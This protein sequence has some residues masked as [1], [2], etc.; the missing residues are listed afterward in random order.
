MKNFTKQTS[1]SKEEFIF[2]DQDKGQFTILIGDTNLDNFKDESYE[3]NNL[4]KISLRGAAI[5]KSIREKTK[6]RIEKINLEIPKEMSEV[7]EVLLDYGI[8]E[9]PSEDLLRLIK[10]EALSL[11]VKTKLESVG[12]LIKLSRAAGDLGYKKENLNIVWV[13]KDECPE[14][15]SDEERK[16]VNLQMKVILT[17]GINIR[18][19]IEG[20]ILI[21]NNENSIIPS[22]SKE[23]FNHFFFITMKEQG[24][25][26]ITIDELLINRASKSFLKNIPD[27]S[28][29]KI[30]SMF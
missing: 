19:Y 2:S 1:N 27:L 5:R 21:T 25:Q 14:E 11:I 26:L 29:W 28:I 22:K 3:I 7:K 15:I 18:K 20:R 16:T 4:R 8:L 6:K 12:D 23:F 24:K 9:E 30:D 13:L 17:G 10:G